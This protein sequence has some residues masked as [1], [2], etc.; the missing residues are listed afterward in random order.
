MGWLERLNQAR[1]SLSVRVALGVALPFLLVFILLSVMHYT[2]E[3]ALL[4]EQIELTATQI[5]EVTLGSLRHAMLRKQ[6]IEEIVRDVGS[7]DNIES[8]LLINP[9]GIA[10]AASGANTLEAFD[11][12]SPGWL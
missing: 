11:V 1:K 9:A 8:V 3:L 7:M 5:G 4:E 6:H 12:G 2:R 10:T